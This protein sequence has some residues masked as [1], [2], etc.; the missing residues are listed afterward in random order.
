MR[1]IKCIII[2]LRVKSHSHKHKPHTLK[3]QYIASF[4]FNCEPR[5]VWDGQHG[6]NHA[7]LEEQEEAV[8][9]INSIVYLFRK[10]GFLL[11][12]A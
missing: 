3:V 12:T 5:R 11:P 2:I 4:K 1:C 10:L 7:C 9:L 6:K 8:A